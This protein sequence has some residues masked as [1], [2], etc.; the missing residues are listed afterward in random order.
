MKG[1]LSSIGWVLALAVLFAQSGSP[2][3]IVHA[4]EANA[5]V[6]AQIA[7]LDKL[8]NA[9]E[10][11]AKDIPKDTFDLQAALELTDLTPEGILTW[12]RDNTYFVPYQGAL[13]GAQG[14]LMDRVGNSLDR[15]MLLQGLLQLLGYETQ[16]ARAQ[17]SEAQA[18]DILA[19]TNPIPAE[20]ALPQTADTDINAE[21]KKYVSE[22]GLDGAQLTQA[23]E[24]AKQQRETLQA[25]LKT[26]VASQTEFLMNALGNPSGD[27]AAEK[28]KQVVSLQDHWWVQYQEGGVWVDLD[29]TLPDAVPNQKIVAPS[30]TLTASTLEE[31]PQE[32]LHTLQIKV[33]LECTLDSGL[34]E[35]TL[36]ESPVLIPANLLGQRIAISH[37]PVNMPQTFDSSDSAALKDLILEQDRWFPVLSIGSQQL[38]T[39][40]YTSSCE[41]GVA[42]PPSPGTAVGGA[43]E[44][45]LDVFGGMDGTDM[46]QTETDE[47]VTAQWIDYTLHVP[48]E[49]DEII[50]RQ[51]FDELGPE[52]RASGSSLYVSSEQQRLN[53]RTALLGSTDVLPL[54]GQLSPDYVAWMIS[55]SL[56]DNRRV[57]QDALLGK[58][59]R[60]D[61]DASRY[62]SG[63]LYSLSLARQMLVQINGVYLAQPNL[64]SYHRQWQ[65]NQ[66]GVFEPLE[67]FDIVTNTVE[68]DAKTRADVFVARL[69]QGVLDTNA[70][71]IIGALECQRADGI[72]CASG[73]NAGET[74][75][76]SPQQ[77][78]QWIVVRTAN[79]LSQVT[80]P[81][82]LL[83]RVKQDLIQGY[84]VVLPKNVVV[85]L[86]SSV[87]W[88]VDPNS[89]ASLGMGDRGWGQ[90]MLEYQFLVNLGGFGFCMAGGI[91]GNNVV[92]STVFCVAGFSLGVGVM[93]TV[94]H[95][96][97]IL[98]LLAMGSYGAGGLGK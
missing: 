36:V 83:T 97:G 7:N 21:L 96:A 93:L 35:T 3:Y 31:L 72:L 65:Q 67:G 94:G 22:F 49:S 47:R 84:V 55:Q 18:Q 6:E 15:A 19:K 69:E 46:S 90:D 75:A 68:I 61:V 88:R 87:W 53:W 29:P 51:I 27:V 4:Q 41:I 20:G 56:L 95:T 25:E 10:A 14:V 1:W 30:E 71:A 34:Q 54:V 38:F 60:A 33:V 79:D 32:L 91:G 86:E 39:S 43:L 28:A 44:N 80:L 57:M 89:G 9:L 13:R 5:E 66:E 42:T 70:E 85:P 64:V 23:L 12:V 11:A 2:A 82:D 45:A 52:A 78:L 24:Q 77:G 92:R 76:L 26:R 40:D 48:G 73:R 63:Q 74:L 8:F 16:L 58:D 37:V 81:E 62:P 17:L 98:A 59:S 50:R